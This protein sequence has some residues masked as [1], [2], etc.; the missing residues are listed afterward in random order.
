MTTQ[1]R[2][3]SRTELI[4]YATPTG[5]LGEWCDDFSN[6]VAAIGPTLAQTY[7]MHC[8]LTGFFRRTASQRSRVVDAVEKLLAAAGPVPLGAVEVVS[9]RQHDEWIGLELSSSWLLDLAARFATEHEIEPGDDPIRLKDW[10]HLSFAYG[11]DDLTQYTSVA[12]PLRRDPS[13]WPADVRA[14]VW[15]V[16]LWER[17]GPGGWSRLTGGSDDTEASPVAL[18]RVSPST[19]RPT[20]RE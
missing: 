2:S 7:P 14:A 17:T 16:A 20:A 11:V 9:L 19:G 4:L 18:R 3:E 5:L 1:E 8:T 15:E 10:L 13:Q 6:A 12:S